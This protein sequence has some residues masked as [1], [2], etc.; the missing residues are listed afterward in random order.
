VLLHIQMGEQERR[1][2]LGRDFLV[3]QDEQFTRAVT[4]LLGDGAVWLE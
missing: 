4:D 1:V 3:R 2:R